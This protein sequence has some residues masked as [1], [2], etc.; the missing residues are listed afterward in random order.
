M[1]LETE[2]LE[3]GMTERGNTSLRNAET[4][5][6][7]FYKNLNIDS[8]LEITYMA[9]NYPAW[10]ISIVTKTLSEI[11]THIEEN[12]TD[13]WAVE[14]N[15]IGLNT[16]CNAPVDLEYV[17]ERVRDHLYVYRDNKD[18]ETKDTVTSIHDFLEKHE[19]SLDITDIETL[20]QES[21][22]V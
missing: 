16:E 8:W 18:F 13:P 6:V 10:N 20:R 14:R 3:C 4:G 1:D 21:D 15:N 7:V 5:S 19:W 12:F 9:E 11:R 17:M 22:E 2:L